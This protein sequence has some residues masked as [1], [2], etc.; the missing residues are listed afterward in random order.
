VT[1]NLSLGASAPKRKNW[2]CGCRIHQCIASWR[3]LDHL[4]VCL[5]QIKYFSIENHGAEE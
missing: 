2:Q 1:A 5:I 3:P 4:L